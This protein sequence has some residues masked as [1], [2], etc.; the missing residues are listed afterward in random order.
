MGLKAI[1]WTLPVL[2][3]A[4]VIAGLCGASLWQTGTPELAHGQLM[5]F[6]AEAA[7]Y[8]T[9]L[10]PSQGVLWEGIDD[11]SARASLTDGSAAA[12]L[13]FPFDGAGLI[14][15]VRSSGRYRLLYGEQV[16]T[17]WQGRFWRYELREGMPVPLEGEVEWL[18]P[19]GPK[20]YWRGRIRRM[21]YEYAR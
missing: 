2:V 6:L 4:I 15:T 17:P 13:E 20:A 8:P 19:E 11:T 1:L 14:R 21:E 7:W 10:L 18:L 16:P 12:S 3:V 9:A 5:R